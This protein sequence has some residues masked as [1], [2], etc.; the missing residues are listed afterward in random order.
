[1][2]FDNTLKYQKG[3]IITLSDIMTQ[4]EFNDLSADFKI[5][6]VRTYKEPTSSFTLTCYIADYQPKAA[7]EAKTIMLMVK[8]VGDD[9]ELR[10]FYKDQEGATADYIDSI[11]IDEKDLVERF[12]VV[13][14]I[15]E[16]D[17][18][19]TWDKQR[20]TWFGVNSFSTE[21]G[22]D[23]KTLAEYFT[24]DNANNHCFMEWTGD[25]AKGWLEIW[26][27]CEIRQEDVEIFNVK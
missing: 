18:N 21:T 22:A 26:Y 13:L 7:Q 2:K 9:F 11:I 24:N 6:E 5:K 19:V 16:E 10:V 3:D 25:A 20:E 8:K 12:E 1:M 17:I 4:Q 15:N 27:G 23:Q 14:H